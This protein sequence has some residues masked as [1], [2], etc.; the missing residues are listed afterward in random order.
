MTTRLPTSSW[1]SRWCRKCWSKCPRICC[2]VQ[3]STDSCSPCVNSFVSSSSKLIF[4]LKSLRTCLNHLRS[5]ETPDLLR[6]AIKTLL[7]LIDLTTSLGSSQ[8]FDQHC[9]VLGEGVIGTV[10][11]YAYDDA[12]AV[13]ATVDVLPDI[14]H[15]MGLGCA[16]YLKVSEFS[17][18]ALK[19][20]FLKREREGSH[21]AAY[22]PIVSETSEPLVGEASA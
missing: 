12:E 11:F 20:C 1:V 8:R 10:W 2:D 15:A 19:C 3:A 22:P 6:A 17:L 5:A 9:S 13:L 4:F 21:L 14:L 16:R 7:T 18:S